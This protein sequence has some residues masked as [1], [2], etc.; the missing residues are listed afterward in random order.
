MDSIM[1]GIEKSNLKG[2]KDIKGYFGYFDSKENKISEYKLLFIL[3]NG[4]CLFM[5]YSPKDKRDRKN[6]KY[7]HIVYLT[8][9]LDLIL[10]ELNID[11][12][13]FIQQK[14]KRFDNDAITSAILN[15]QIPFFYDTG[16]IDIDGKVI[17]DYYRY[18]VFEKSPS[19]TEKQEKTLTLL[20]KTLENEHYKIAIQALISDNNINTNLDNVEEF[21]VDQDALLKWISMLEDDIDIENFYKIIKV[22]TEQ[23]R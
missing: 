12:K 3:P 15:L 18:T 17:D 6:Y 4:K 8:N 11:K 14:I 7:A 21:I 13:N 22:E 2:A 19:F 20:K 10:K 9:A 5:P 16:N 1:Y 23:T